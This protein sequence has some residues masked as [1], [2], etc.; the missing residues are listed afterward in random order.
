MRGG[1]TGRKGV[2]LRM[3]TNELEHV[4]E[5]APELVMVQ[6]WRP[7]GALLLELLPLLPAVYHIV[8]LLDTNIRITFPISSLLEAN[9]SN[10][11]TAV[12]TRKIITSATRSEVPY[13]CVAFYSISMA[14]PREGH[15]H[16][17][18]S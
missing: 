13:T 9:I 6:P 10:A 3:V 16:E 18:V 8:L 5:P 15:F 2:A 7:A 4:V 1:G 12:L 14:W 11:D 17:R